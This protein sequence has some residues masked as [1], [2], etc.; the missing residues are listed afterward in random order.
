M[1]GNQV[2]LRDSLEDGELNHD[3]YYKYFQQMEEVLTEHISNTNVGKEFRELWLESWIRFCSSSQTVEKLKV[4]MPLFH[5]EIDHFYR[6]KEMEDNL[7][8]ALSSKQPMKKD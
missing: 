5:E 1:G 7:E 8:K 6:I 3:Q 2:D 4:E